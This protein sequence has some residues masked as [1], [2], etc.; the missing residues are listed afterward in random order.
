VAAPFRRVSQTADVE[1][2]GLFEIVIGR[3]KQYCNFAAPDNTNDLRMNWESVA[4][5]PI[6]P[7]IDAKFT[8]W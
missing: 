7:C 3:V 2:D 8:G 5:A 1:R 4:W 6:W